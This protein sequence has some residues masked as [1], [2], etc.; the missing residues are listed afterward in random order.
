MWAWASAR[1][2]LRNSSVTIATWSSNLGIYVWISL[3]DAGCNRSLDT[4]PFDSLICFL[5]YFT[6]IHS[7]VHLNQEVMNKNTKISLSITRLPI[8]NIFTRNVSASAWTVTSSVSAAPQSWNC[9]CSTGIAPW[10]ITVPSKMAG[11]YCFATLSFMT[12]FAPVR[13][14]SLSLPVVELIT[15]G[16]LVLMRLLKFIASLRRFQLF[17][18]G[19]CQKNIFIVQNSAESSDW[20]SPITPHTFA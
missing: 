4:S 1:W 17:I 13:T 7:F 3:S 2:I 18:N 10:L 16:S 11:R 19:S 14:F 5:W 9:C 8:H 6:I 15:G 12:R 20:S